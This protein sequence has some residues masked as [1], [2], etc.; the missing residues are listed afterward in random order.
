MNECNNWYG[1]QEVNYNQFANVVISVGF[2]I[3]F[4]SAVL[5]VISVIRSSPDGSLFFIRFMI[6]GMVLAVEGVIAS[7]FKVDK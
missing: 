4:L 3:T 2:F 7:F 6:F 1:K 5:C